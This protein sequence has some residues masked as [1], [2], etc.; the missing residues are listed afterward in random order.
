MTFVLG[1]RLPDPYYDWVLE[2]GIRHLRVR[3][4]LECG[5]RYPT[6]ELPLHL[7]WRGKEANCCPTHSEV[8]GAITHAI[9][10]VTARKGKYFS[11]AMAKVFSYGAVYRR[12]QCRVPG[13]VGVTYS[14]G[15]PTRWTTMEV[16]TD[17]L[18]RRD[19]TL[20]PRCQG[21][22]KI[23]GKRVGKVVLP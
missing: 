19:V 18:I 5:H 15:K 4:C 2:E 8:P 14:I 3:K 22:S 9:S 11:E 12:R 21:V 23:E 17:G 7:R 13:C 16:A 10:P 1:T 20:C 6:A